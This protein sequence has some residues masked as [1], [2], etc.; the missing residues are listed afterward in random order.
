VRSATPFELKVVP[1]AFGSAS[2]DVTASACDSWDTGTGDQPLSPTA[3]VCQVEVTVTVG[4]HT[5]N[6]VAPLPPYEGPLSFD[7]QGGEILP[8]GCGCEDEPQPDE[9][10]YVPAPTVTGTST[11]ASAPASLASEYGGSTS[12][13]VEVTGTGLDPMTFSIATLVYPPGS[14]PT[15]DSEIYPVQESGTSMILDAPGIL[16]GFESP[17]V[18]P[19]GIGVGFSSLAGSSSNTTQILYA[20][21]PVV[22]KVVNTA[23]GKNGVP[24]SPTCGNPPP[25]SGCGTPV[26]ITG[27]GMDQVFGPI[28]FVDDITGT[29]LSLQYTYN[30]ASDSKITTEALTQNPDLVDVSVCSETS[31][32]YNPP[33]DLLYVYP[34]GNPKITA[35][36][37]TSGPAH[38]SNTVKITGT[39]L[40]CALAVV[41]GTVPTEEVANAPALLDCGQTGEVLA[42]APPGKVGKVKVTIVTAESYFTGASSNSVTYTYRAS[43]P[44][45][46]RDVSA[47]AG[48]GRAT[49]TWKAPA[50]DGGHPV[51]GYI[52]KATAKGQKTKTVSVSAG[53]RRHV[54]TGLKAHIAWTFKVQAKNRLGTGLAGTSNTVK[55][56]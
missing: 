42:T 56:T 2:G 15:E 32:S 22:T 29:D 25:A 23:T 40:G 9:Y 41:F 26:T 44:S 45:A 11:V 38:G 52:V 18:E 16:S 5:S 35:I 6:T 53:T 7:N 10:D 24:A 50:Q 30:I 51:T 49:V 27:Q 1:P 46:P 20:G 47:K 17:T 37:A 39:N 54:F 12:N 34:P 48:R 33:G 36:S 14:A 21:V 3:D 43:T 28:G 4:A 8:P 19:V 55:P 13:L 31:C